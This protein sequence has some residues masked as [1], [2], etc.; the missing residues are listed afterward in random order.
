MTPSSCT[1]VE[2]AVIGGGVAGT[3]VAAVLARRGYD[4][5]LIDPRGRAAADFRAE[6]LTGGQVAALRRLGLDAPVLATATPIGRLRIARFGRVV[7]ERANDEWG[8]A[9]A[10]LVDGLRSTVPLRALRITRAARIAADND[11]ATITLADATTIRARVAIIATG[12]GKALLDNLAIARVDAVR[13]HS[14]AI[15]FDLVAAQGMPP[16]V[17]LTYFGEHPVDR[18]AYLTPFPI[19]DRLRVNLFTYHRPGDR[20]IAALREAPL[21]AV[22]ALMPGLPPLLPPLDHATAPVIRPIHLFASAGHLRPGV[23]LIGDAFANTCPTGGSGL[24]KALNDVERLVAILPGWLA[25]PGLSR[26]K[27]AA[28]YDDPAK[29]AG[30]AAARAMVRHARALALARD[31]LW[32]ARRHTGFYV[33]RLRWRLRT[34]RQDRARRGHLPEVAPGR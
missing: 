23:V 29:R 14:L 27:V 26:C 33:Q 32:T 11:G 34:F 3:A 5:A 4:V 17:P 8:L 20:W 12:L 30:D 13:D 24:A 16:V 25:T 1:N 28:F 21:D 22:A 9:Y 6:K 19:G 7:E 2:V 10:A 18:T 15:G 31:P